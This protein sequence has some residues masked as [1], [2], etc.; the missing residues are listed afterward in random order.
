MIEIELIEI[1]DHDSTVVVDVL[2]Q[3]HI[4]ITILQKTDFFAQKRWFHAVC[5]KLIK[6]N[7][8]EI[9][10]ISIDSAI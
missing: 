5:S 7:E 8:F 6:R 9:T 2:I 10:T 4:I 1:S 3:F